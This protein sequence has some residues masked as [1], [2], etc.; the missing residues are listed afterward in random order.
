MYGQTLTSRHTLAI[1]E[2]GAACFGLQNT[3]VPG[4]DPEMPFVRWGGRPA[5]LLDSPKHAFAVLEPRGRWTRVDVDQV[6]Q[7]GEV[8]TE[9]VWRAEFEPE[10]G[11]LI[12]RN[13]PK[14]P[15]PSHMALALAAAQKKVALKYADEDLLA[16]GEL[17]EERAIQA[18]RSGKDALDP[19]I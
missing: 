12:L 13:L 15:F 5:V 14:E 6:S 17:L 11:P 7:F 1:S 18:L 8:V 16:H 9:Q 2:V 10:F 4:G 3:Y 19:L